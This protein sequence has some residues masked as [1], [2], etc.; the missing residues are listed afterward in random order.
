MLD[1]KHITEYSLCSNAKEQYKML[2]LLEKYLPHHQL[3]FLPFLSLQNLTQ[4][5]KEKAILSF[6]LF[7]WF[8]SNVFSLKEF[9]TIVCSILPA[10]EP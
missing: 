5:K 10:V 3:L 6:K 7:M 2:K 1:R 4:M 9:P 8:F